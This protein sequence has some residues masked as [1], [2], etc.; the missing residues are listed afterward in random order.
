MKK[1]TKIKEV[2]PT[3]QYDT[4]SGFDDANCSCGNGTFWIGIELEISII[5]TKCRA[6]FIEDEEYRTWVFDK[7]LSEKD[8]K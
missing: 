3:I 7:Y 2:V 4:S 6:I 1:K 8:I 5:C